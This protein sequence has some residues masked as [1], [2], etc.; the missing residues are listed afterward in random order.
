MSR[1][2]NVEI[3]RR[4]VQA[5]TRRPKPDF[6]TVNELYHPDHELL[7]LPARVEGRSSRGVAEYREWLTTW[8]EVFE[9]WEAEIEEVTAIDDE[10][11]MVVMTVDARSRAGVPITQRF[12]QVATITDRKVTRT[13]VWSSRE[14]ALAAAGARR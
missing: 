12:W 9:S 14:Q 8:T 1:E 2:E 13:E 7:S 4:A 5:A 6:A 11:V 10:H 3:V